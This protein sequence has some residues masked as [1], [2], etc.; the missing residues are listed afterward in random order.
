VVCIYFIAKYDKIEA[1]QEAIFFN[2]P[3]R[4]AEENHLLV[5]LYFVTFCDKNRSTPR[6]YFIAY[7]LKLKPALGGPLFLRKM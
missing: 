6:G 5:H 4:V 3:L 1:H 2:N 7:L